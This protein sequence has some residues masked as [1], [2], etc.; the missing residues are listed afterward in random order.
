M[1]QKELKDLTGADVLKM[2][3][4]QLIGIVRETNRPPGGVNSVSR[5]AQRG[6]LHSGSRILEIGTSTGFTAIELARLVGCHITAIDI[7]PTSL[8]EARDRAEMLGVAGRIRF[9]VQD[10]TNLSYDDGEFDMVFCGNV[11]SL[12]SDRDKALREYSRVIKNSGYIAAIPMYYIKEP[13]EALLN[14]VSEAIHVRISPHQKAYWMEFFSR[15]PLQAYWSEDYAFDYIDDARVDAFVQD[16]LTRPHLQALPSA[17]GEVIAQRYREFMYL[18]RDNLSH[19][20]YTLLLLRKEL[21][22]IDPELYTSRP[23]VS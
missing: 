11:T 17:T 19:M 21:V 18:F 10:A 9:E 16:I 8:A 7:N 3:Y 14:A 6:F 5:I 13:S 23:V 1:I 22:R 20:G 15:E 2:D 4:N 12:V